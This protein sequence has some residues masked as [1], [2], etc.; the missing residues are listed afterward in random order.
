MKEINR[1]RPISFAILISLGF[2]VASGCTHMFEQPIHKI[3]VD[4]VA[5]KI[6]LNVALILTDNFR[7]A[8]YQREEM[9]D[10]WIIPIGENLV[11]HSVELM[12]RVF[13]YSV[14]LDES[15]NKSPNKNIKYVMTPELIFFD[16]A[17]GAF[18]G[19]ESKISICVKWTLT[20]TSGKTLWVETIKGI[21]IGKSG[22]I[23]NGD[24]RIKTKVQNALQDL[25]NNSQNAILSSKLLRKLG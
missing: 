19:S 13:A 22:N 20:D 7:N 24:E 16:W 17:F 23:F 5:E 14:T 15:I 1:F 3:N 8:K 21:G 10:K 2:F 4:P 9:G 18:A 12:N 6:D 25:F 11:H